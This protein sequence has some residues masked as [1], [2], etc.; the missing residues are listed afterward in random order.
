MSRLRIYPNYRPLS[1]ALDE[2]VVMASAP[3]QLQRVVFGCSRRIR[4]T[5]A[6]RRRPRCQ[7]SSQ[8]R[9]KPCVHSA[10][11]KEVITC[12]GFTAPKP[13]NPIYRNEA[14]NSALLV[15]EANEH[16]ECP[17]NL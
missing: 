17:V 13:S 7:S 9:F 2:P 11:D 16:I 4:G 3:S 8:F 10:P 15:R 14:A 6:K 12:N 1:H 5:E